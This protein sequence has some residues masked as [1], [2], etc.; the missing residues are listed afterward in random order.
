MFQ[1]R[2]VRLKPNKLQQEFF[3]KNFGAKRFVW[4]WG[5]DIYNKWWEENKE[6]EKKDRTKRPSTFDLTNRL[7]LLKNTQ[8][9]YAWLK[10]TDSRLI[11]FTLEALDKA[12]KKFFS[13]KARY[14]KFKSKKDSRQSY[15]TKTPSY[16]RLKDPSHILLPKI[17][18]VKFYG[19]G[20]LPD[21]DFKQATISTDGDHYYCSVLMDIPAKRMPLATAL[22]GIDLGIKTAI[23]CSNGKTYSLK[24]NIRLERRLKRAQR[25]LSRRRKGS[26]RR[27]KALKRVRILHRRISNQRKDFIHKTTSSLVSENQVIRMEDLNT[28]GMLKNHRLA[29]SIAS[30]SF[31]EI[32]RQLQYKCEWYGRT[33]EVVDRW[34]PSSQLCSNCGSRNKEMKNLNKR[35]FVCHACGHTLDR[36][37]NAAINISKYSTRGERGTCDQGD[38]SSTKEGKALPACSKS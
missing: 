7:N 9:E 34:Y 36:D 28:K 2:K 33:F 37:L 22:I 32:K 10:E 29:C 24:R 1:S 13:G 5:L 12:F 15:S 4:N 20:Y 14:P 16:P 18:S 30:S 38:L 3:K 31:G 23:T 11:S 25:I 27:L 26:L 21:V 8:E 17:K 35:T 6:K 19:R